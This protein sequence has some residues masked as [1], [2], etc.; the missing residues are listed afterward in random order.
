MVRVC[1]SR[2][3]A[4]LVGCCLESCKSTPR[5]SKLCQLQ[6]GGMLWPL[7]ED[8]KIVVLVVVA[9]RVPAK[10]KNVFRVEDMGV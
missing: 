8:N 5:A 10:E 3:V 2:L 4:A 6:F 7:G 9:R 1:N